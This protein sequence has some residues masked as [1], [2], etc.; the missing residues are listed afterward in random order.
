MKQRI[1]PSSN[2]G[3][4]ISYFILLPP[5]FWGRI[6]AF[7]EVSPGGTHQ[8]NS[9][10]DDCKPFMDAVLCSGN[11]SHEALMCN[12]ALCQL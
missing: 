6:W 9:L 12:S 10:S 3:L 11:D 8:S 5:R 2:L 1:A 7:Q 4:A